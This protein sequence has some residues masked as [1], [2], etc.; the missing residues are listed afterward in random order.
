MRHPHAV[1]HIYWKIV[2]TEKCS[3]YIKWLNKLFVFNFKL[4]GF[5]NLILSMLW[6]WFIVLRSAIIPCI[7]FSYF[8]NTKRIILS[9]LETLNWESEVHLNLFFKLQ[10]K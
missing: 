5:I 8:V 10:S 6:T 2:K 1:S 9:S 7:Y 3:W 4:G